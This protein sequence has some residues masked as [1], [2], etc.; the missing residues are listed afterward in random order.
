MLNPRFRMVVA[1]G[2]EETGMEF[3]EHAQGPS[4]LS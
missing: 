4:T 3:G 1:S 2:K